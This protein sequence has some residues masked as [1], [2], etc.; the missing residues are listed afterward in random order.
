MDTI[1]HYLVNDIKLNQDFMYR[2]INELA[3][4]RSIVIGEFPKRESEKEYPFHDYFYM[5]DIQNWPD[6]ITKNNIKAIHAHKGNHGARIVPLA[7][8]YGI[9][10]ITS[11][12]GQDASAHHNYFEVNR[13]KFTD[14]IKEG[15]LFLPVCK[16]FKKEMVQLGFPKD[17]IGV[18]YGGID[19]DRFT[20]S[21]R[22]MPKSRKIRILS[23]GRFIEKKGFDYLLV[24]FAMVHSKYPNTEL[25]I[26]GKGSEKY[27]EKLEEITRLLNI[28]DAVTF[29]EPMYNQFIAEEMKNAHLFCLASYTTNKGNIEGIPNV[30]KEAM[31]SG[32]PVVSTK[33]AGIPELIQHGKS[34]LL[35]E[36]R[37]IEGLA[38]CIG[39]LIENPRSWAKLSYHARLK[40]NKD[41]DLR[42]QIAVQE[43]Y[44][45]LV[46]EF[47]R[48]VSKGENYR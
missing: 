14:L 31:A 8:E 28:Q 29:K 20:Y 17:R 36:E 5:G 12:R 39:K 35:V 18:M 19:L 7:K 6:F 45:D 16:Y 30:L 22:R 11:F 34:G 21:V 4:Y 40:V 41:F 24:A 27:K 10:L 26:I 37:D 23:V 13:E 32:L 33:H 48:L 43:K 47:S 2:Q 44:Y 38:K 1:A 42:K 9:P 46:I 3:R 25:V 15:S